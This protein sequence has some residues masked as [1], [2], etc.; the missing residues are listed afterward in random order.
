MRG[1]WPGQEQDKK[2]TGNTVRGGLGKDAGMEITDGNTKV[3]LFIKF[4]V[5]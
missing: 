1:K 2:K 4:H 5:K 3:S